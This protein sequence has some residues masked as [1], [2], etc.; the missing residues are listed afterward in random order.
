M[1]IS[2]PMLQ[3]KLDNMRGVTIMGKIIVIPSFINVFSF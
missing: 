2:L 3:E 1:A